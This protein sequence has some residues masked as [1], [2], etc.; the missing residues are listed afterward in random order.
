MEPGTIQKNY[1]FSSSLESI[2]QCKQILENSIDKSQKKINS[3]RK[4]LL[5]ER[6]KNKELQVQLDNFEVMESKMRLLQEE[7]IEKN[8]EIKK[9]KEQLSKVQ[10]QAEDSD[11]DTWKELYETTKYIKFS[12]N[13]DYIEIS[14]AV[15]ETLDKILSSNQMKN[16]IASKKRVLEE[17]QYL[18]NT[19]CFEKL[20]FCIC[21]LNIDIICFFEDT[22][23]TCSTL[24][25][26]NYPTPNQKHKFY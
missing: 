20:L 24:D 7:V 8:K 5:Q 2:L 15:K 26:E 25:T 10:H 6:E 1:N 18:A 23:N 13:T 9:F 19:L 11:S 4:A 17:I 22:L 16:F 12:T 3:I 21:R 14:K